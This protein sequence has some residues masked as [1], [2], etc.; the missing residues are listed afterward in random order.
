MFWYWL[1]VDAESPIY[2]HYVILIRPKNSQIYLLSP[3]SWPLFS[4]RPSPSLTWTTIMP[5]IHSPYHSQCAQ[6]RSYLCPAQDLSVLPITLRIKFKCF[7]MTLYDGAHLPLQPLSPSS[8]CPSMSSYSGLS[9]P[10]TGSPSPECTVLED[11]S[12][13]ALHWVPLIFQVSAWMS[14]SLGSPFWHHLCVSLAGT[15]YHHAA[16]LS[17]DII[18]A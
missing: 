11:S 14:R 13:P 4:F 8:L 5:P 10:Q 2:H 17:Y 18:I 15:L 12:F 16:V 9:D 3:S 6:I 7:N 1:W